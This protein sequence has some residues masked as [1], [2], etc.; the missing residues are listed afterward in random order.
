MAAAAADPPAAAISPH[1]EYPEFHVLPRA[2]RFRGPV[3]RGF[4]RGSK[5]LGIP[6]ANLDPVGLPDDLPPGVYFG[7]ASVGS[8]APVYKAVMSI[9]WCVYVVLRRGEREDGSIVDRHE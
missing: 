5:T 6:T 2:V 3:I 8:G 7:W 4:G 9:G 1:P